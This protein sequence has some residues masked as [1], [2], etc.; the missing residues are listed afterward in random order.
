MSRL[1]EGDISQGRGVVQLGVARKGEP[2][3]ILLVGER[4]GL[5]PQ[6]LRLYP[7]LLPVSPEVHNEGNRPDILLVPPSQLAQ[8]F[9][10]VHAVESQNLGVSHKKVSQTYRNPCR[11]RGR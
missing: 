3:L 11:G 9:L 2:E 10:A 8:E 5:N 7:Q 6:L 4:L 1:I